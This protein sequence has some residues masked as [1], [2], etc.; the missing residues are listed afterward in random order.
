MGIYELGYPI[1][2]QPEVRTLAKHHTSATM[3]LSLA[4][5]F[6]CLVAIGLAM[7]QKEE[8]KADAAAAAAPAANTRGNFGGGFGGRPAGFGG[9][10]FGQGGRPF[11]QGFGQP[12][13][14]QPGFGQPGFGQPGFGQTGFGQT[15]GT[16]TCRYWCKT[17]EGKN[18]C[19]ENNAEAPKNPI[20]TQVSKPGFCPVPRAECPLRGAFG[21]PP[22]SCSNDGGCFGNDRCCFDRCLGQHVCKQPL[23]YQG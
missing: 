16:A 6:T 18:Y 13:F 23:A 10:P 22:Q 2:P 1:E 19:C 5:C 4:I 15:G 8:E 9:R 14:G 12:G 17:P 21:G 11:G 20:T 3:K 7:P